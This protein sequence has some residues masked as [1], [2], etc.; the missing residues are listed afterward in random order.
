V[1]RT[2]AAELARLKVTYPGW[3]IQ[4]SDET[5]FMA[6]R[7]DERGDVRS[8]CAPT[9]AELETALAGAGGRQSDGPC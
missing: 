2:P 4:R 1:S 9:V 8:I 6:E 3:I 7:Q 5:G